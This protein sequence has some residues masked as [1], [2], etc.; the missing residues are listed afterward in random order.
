MFDH[1]R[2][3]LRE[4]DMLVRVAKAG[5]MTRAAKQLHLTPAAVSA[6]VR[7]L[8][9]ELGVRVFERT[10]RSLHPTEEGLVILE[11]CEDMVER[12]ERT[13]DDVRGEEEGELT[14]EVHVSAPADTVYGVL[15]P[16]IADVTRRNPRMRVVVHSSDV[17]LHLHRDAIDVAIRYGRLPDSSIP[18]RKLVETV[19]VLVAS[20]GYIAQHG[21]PSTPDELRSRRCVTLQLSGAPVVSWSLY[22][23][24][25]EVV[26][27]ELESPLCGDG[28]LARQWALEGEGVARKS[29]FDVIDDLETGRLVRVLPGY[30]SGTSLV[31]V[32]FPSRRFLPARVRAL[33][34][35]FSE[36]IQARAARCTAWLSGL[37]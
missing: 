15:A 25:G 22:G 32:V 31:H 14:G 9:E 33:D 34:V 16:V 4:M 30:H 18:A 28:H 8:E 10:T 11:A 24:G 17:V 26:E 5:S 2:M 6:A 29:L 1:G 37:A 35:A 19:A 13:L 3:N 27:V 20:P 12:W 21:A 7:R 23:S 36:A